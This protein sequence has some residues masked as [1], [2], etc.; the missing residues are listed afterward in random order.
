MW[1]RD[2]TV[3]TPGR[4]D[5]G[6]V[7]ECCHARAVFKLFAP[8]LSEEE[9]CRRGLRSVELERV[10]TEI[11]RAAAAVVQDAWDGTP[12]EAPEAV[13]RLLANSRLA[14][15]IAALN[16]MGV[17]TLLPGEYP[18]DKWR[19]M[20]EGTR[21]YLREPSDH[22]GCP[23]VS[24]AVDALSGLIGDFHGSTI[25]LN[26]LRIEPTNLTSADPLTLVAVH[27]EIM[28]AFGEFLAQ[29]YIVEGWSLT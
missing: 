10:S 3:W 26:G 4:H 22:Q 27:P 16:L 7:D 25:F 24:D 20:I 29:K 9:R 17:E 28:I 23:G 11:R 18:R 12:Y 14:T 2:L 15:T 6:Q 8:E 13:H 1:H 21:I 19:D 5:T